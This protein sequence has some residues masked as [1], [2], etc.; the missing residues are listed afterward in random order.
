MKLVSDVEA[1]IHIIG[2]EKGN[3]IITQTGQATPKSKY[4]HFLI[5]HSFSA[6]EWYEKMNECG[7]FDCLS[8][9]KPSKKRKK[10]VEEEIKEI[11]DE[12]AEKEIE[13]EEAVAAGEIDVKLNDN[14]VARLVARTRRITVH[15]EVQLKDNGWFLV[16]IY[17]NMDGLYPL[18]F[19]VLPNHKGYQ[20]FLSKVPLVKLPSKY[21]TDKN[22][23]NWKYN[24]MFLVDRLL[25]ENG[26][27]NMKTYSIFIHRKDNVTTSMIKKLVSQFDQSQRTRIKQGNI[28]IDE[29]LTTVGQN[30]YISNKE[31]LSKK[32]K[33]EDVDTEVTQTD[34]DEVKIID[35][36]M[37][38]FNRINKT[39]EEMDKTIS[40]E[41][42]FITVRNRLI[43]IEKKEEDEL[44]QQ[45]IESHKDDFDDDITDEELEEIKE[46]LHT[47]N[48]SDYINNY[49]IYE[50]CA[51]YDSYLKNESRA[52]KS[53]HKI[54]QKH[55]IWEKV[56]KYDR[57]VGPIIAARI[58]ANIDFIGTN[59][60]SSVIKYVGLD[61]VTVR[62][63]H[64][65]GASMTEKELHDIVCMLYKDWQI[66]LRN[67][68]LNGMPELNIDTY[69]V[70][71]K[72]DCLPTYDSFRIVN[73]IF[74]TFEKS[75]PKNVEDM[76]VIP[77]FSSIVEYIWKNLIIDERITT[78]G[79]DYVVRKRARSMSDKTTNT[80][81][82]EKGKVKVKGGLGYNA[83]LKS[84]LKFL[85]ASSLLKAKNPV[86]T[87][88]YNNEKQ[89]LRQQCIAMGIDPEG[90]GTKAHIHSKAL[91]VTIQRYL[92]N[93]WIKVREIYNLPTNGGTYYE[94]KILGR[95][96]HGI[97]PAVFV[98]K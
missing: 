85:L 14:D 70:K 90:K 96:L 20:T 81:I 56:M 47:L 29:V 16:P 82:D 7:G 5:M 72:S 52:E 25:E 43:E 18:M 1:M 57:G 4:E 41:A 65:D 30:A 9:K 36:I 42:T 54:V 12:I 68:T 50:S 26:I 6:D 40:K 19:K 91:R 28:L 83:R 60:P 38:S 35:E 13:A 64:E 15:S 97:D 93:L 24:S 86:Y 51:I 69:D 92:E 80:Y 21:F 44:V 62:P 10:T 71:Y 73:D 49:V 98:K 39:A 53:L 84:T 78:N 63:N 46:N 94:G 61:Q 37:K 59:H 76:L 95:H 45:Y 58:I 55:E 22:D 88:I 2:K 67:T 66:I 17:E 32:K 33:G 89:R 31:N 11:D 74:I 75:K 8:K 23:G 77:G 79:V 87:E 27:F 48:S 34:I 3:F